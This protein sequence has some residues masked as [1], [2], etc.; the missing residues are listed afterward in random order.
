MRGGI[1]MENRYRSLEELLMVL[2]VE[3]LIQR[4]K[5]QAGHTLDNDRILLS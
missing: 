2:T 4:F 1:Q 5:A 3:D